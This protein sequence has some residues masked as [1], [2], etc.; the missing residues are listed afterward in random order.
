MEAPPVCRGNGAP[1]AS[2]TCENGNSVEAPATRRGRGSVLETSV[3]C[4]GEG[5]AAGPTPGEGSNTSD[6]PPPG[7]GSFP[8][9]RA[10]MRFISSL[11]FSSCIL[12]SGR[13]F[14]TTFSF[15]TITRFSVSG[16]RLLC[17]IIN[18]LR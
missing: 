3:T 18:A 4:S 17:N 10:L 9:F 12:L 6:V 14:E 11:S 7:E 16:I 5:A 15:C 8:G 13:G 2:T 1:P